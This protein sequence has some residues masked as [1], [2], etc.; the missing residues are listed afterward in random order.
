MVLSYT[1][2]PEQDAAL[3]DFLAT[4]KRSD[5]QPM[6]TTSQQ[7]FASRTA[8]WVNALVAEVKERSQQAT[9]QY[10]KEM[11]TVYQLATPTEQAML[12]RLRQKYVSPA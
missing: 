9:V 11:T 3:V 5:R 7:Y 1:S 6:G 12:D 10:G 8:H 2:T 4:L